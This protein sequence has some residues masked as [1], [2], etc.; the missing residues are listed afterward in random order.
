LIKHQHPSWHYCNSP[1][2]KGRSLL[3][4]PFAFQSG[5]ITL[6]RFSSCD[7]SRATGGHHDVS[8]PFG[9]EEHQTVPLPS[10]TANNTSPNSR[11]PN[12]G[13]EENPIQ[14]QL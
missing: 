8:T 3:T 12:H 4:T 11:L 7:R 2:K 9:C 14:L 10:S 5:Y 13:P 6:G 1:A